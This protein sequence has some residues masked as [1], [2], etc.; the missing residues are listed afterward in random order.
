L[1]TTAPKQNQKQKQNKKTKNKMSAQP[2]YKTTFCVRWRR[3]GFCQYGS[4]CGFAHGE[5]DLRAHCKYKASCRQGL[6]CQYSHHPEEIEF[7]KWK[8]ERNA[9]KIIPNTCEMATQTY[10]DEFPSPSPAPP[11]PYIEETILAPPYIEE[12]I[13]APPPEFSNDDSEELLRPDDFCVPCPPVEEKKDDTTLFDE[14]IAQEDAQK[15]PEKKKMYLRDYKDKIKNVE[16]TEKT[17]STGSRNAVI[18]NVTCIKCEK[19]LKLYKLQT[20]T[21]T[22]CFK[23]S[24]LILHSKNCPPVEEKKDDTTL[25]DELIAQEDA[26]KKY[27]NKKMYLRDYKDKI[28]NVELTEKTIVT[29]NQ[30]AVIL[31]ATCI[32]CDKIQKLY[33]LQTKTGRL[34]FRYS[35]LINHFKN[36]N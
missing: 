36:C 31:N 19:I 8:A 22:L 16:W 24:N 2:N 15:N 27:K 10:D 28:K 26:Q 9:P 7:F 20:K 29:G 14:L 11:P 34:G 12:T 21:G 33:K 13:L 1:K 4:D 23:Y 30:N 35:N 3:T 25:L 17:I 6:A 18:L 32:K 5:Y